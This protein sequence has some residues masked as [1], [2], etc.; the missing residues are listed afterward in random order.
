MLYLWDVV[1]FLFGTALGSF[2]GVIADRYNT[3][4]PFFKGRSIC[5][6]C[7][8]KLKNKDLFPIF[9]FLFLKGRCRYCQAKI[10]ISA[11]IIEII[12]GIL[13][14]LVAFETGFLSLEL[15][16]WSL[17][18]GISF[19]LITALF[20][21]ILLISIYDL[22][23]FIIP[24]AF[25][26]AFFV[27]ALSFKLLALSLPAILFNLVTGIILALPFLLIFLISKGRWFGFGDV[28][29]IAVLGFFL[30]P[31]MG[32]SAIILAFWIGAV[33]SVLVLLIKKIK[34]HINLPLFS[35]NFTIKSEIPFGPFLSLGIILSFLLNLDI[36]QIKFLLNVF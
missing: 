9:S 15:R 11:I 35:N 25:L 17:E 13:V 33:F 2:V 19:L 3:G 16:A 32:L 24:D 5:F 34:S 26:I 36:F 31:A 10:P 23:H 21:I 14:V 1:I 22:K 20:S 12:M 6:S 28:K 4:L 7:N 18:M 29:Y 27:F 30:G 8:T